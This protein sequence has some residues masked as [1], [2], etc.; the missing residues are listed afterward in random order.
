[1]DTTEAQAAVYA[2][3]EARGYVDGWL[4]KEFAARQVAKLAEELGELCGQ[5]RLPHC[6]LAFGL[7]SEIEGA[8]IAGRMYFDG[9]NWESAH[10]VDDEAARHELTDC[11]VVILAAAAAM[12]FDVVANAVRISQE[13]VARGKRADKVAQP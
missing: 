2:A 12:G 4:P 9:D 13:N 1:M 6:P 3:V 10:F 8:G 11:A 7:F 5:L